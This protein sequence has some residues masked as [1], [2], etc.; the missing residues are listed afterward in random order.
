MKQLQ[1]K[2]RAFLFTDTFNWLLQLHMVSE[3]QTGLTCFLC[4]TTAF[5]SLSASLSYDVSQRRELDLP[6]N[7]QTHSLLS[8]SVMKRRMKRRRRRRC[9][10]SSVEQTL[11]L[12]SLC[13][14]GPK[15][16]W[17]HSHTHTHLHTHT[18]TL[19]LGRTVKYFLL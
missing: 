8:L 19:N 11:D 7:T 16:S 6:K 2:Q 10:Y 12:V 18:H 9:V 14:S 3:K 5:L 13:C 4:R 1:L 15:N 17:R